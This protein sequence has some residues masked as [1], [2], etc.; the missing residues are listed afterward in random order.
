MAA[1]SGPAVG[2]EYTQQDETTD[3]VNSA[4]VLHRLGI[5]IL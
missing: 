2:W 5:A 1:V 4:D 3:P